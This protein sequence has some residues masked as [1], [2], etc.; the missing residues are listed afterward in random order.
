MLKERLKSINTITLPINSLS[1][2]IEAI[3]WSTE[4]AI[5]AILD[6]LSKKD[7]WNLKKL[8]LISPAIRGRIVFCTEDG[9]FYA[10]IGNAMHNFDDFE[11]LYFS[12]SRGR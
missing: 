5:N 8:H 1:S 10:W 7:N 2:W 3:D 9:V 11:E 4:S 6:E 12:M